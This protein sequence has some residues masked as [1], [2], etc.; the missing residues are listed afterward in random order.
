M[1]KVDADYNCDAFL[2]RGYQFDDNSDNVQALV[3]GD[4]LNFQI[5]LIAGHVP[6]YAVR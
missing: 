3:A 2:C 5:D 6:G 4:S 1:A